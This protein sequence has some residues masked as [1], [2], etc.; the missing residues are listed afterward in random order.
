[1]F[2]VASATVLLLGAV[3]YSTFIHEALLGFPLSPAVSYLS[4]YSA[5]SSPY[6]PIFATSDVI[7]ALCSFA[8]AGLLWFLH[9]P[10][11][12]IAHKLLL[13]ALAGQALF[14][15]LDVAFPLPCAESLPSCTGETG[16]TVH[17]AASVAVAAMQMLVVVTAAFLAVRLHHYRAWF[18]ALIVVYLVATVV[19]LAGEAFGYP[20]GYSQR[21]Q[22]GVAATTVA[23]VWLLF[24]YDAKDVDSSSRMGV[25]AHRL[26]PALFRLPR[27]S[28]ADVDR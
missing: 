1:M 14:T 27:G 4:E 26:P 8:G 7:W 10:R 12:G 16:L 25:P 5:L 28:R 3:A 23:T 17:V 11:L 20:V 9:R 6:R 18:V 15:L 21:V 19:L 22:I 2:K 24:S 13:F